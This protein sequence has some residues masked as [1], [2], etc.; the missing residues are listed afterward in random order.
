MGTEREGSV[1]PV[2]DCHPL[3]SAVSS[4]WKS[5]VA[6]G[7]CSAPSG[8]CT[9]SMKRRNFWKLAL[10]LFVFFLNSLVFLHS[11]SVVNL[12]PSYF[13]FHFFYVNNHCFSS[14]QFSL[15]LCCFVLL[16]FTSF[17]FSFS[18]L[19]ALQNFWPLCFSTLSLLSHIVLLVFS[20]Y[21][22]SS[23]LIFAFPKKIFFLSLS[24]CVY[25]TASMDTRRFSLM[26]SK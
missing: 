1:R 23:M 25:L 8:V 22:S 3:H 16:C 2:L 14:S 4:L 24:F 13:P 19:T 15:F 21:S 20:T 18:L 7:F 12:L 10:M 5:W 11:F 9:F 26:S 6:L 17:P